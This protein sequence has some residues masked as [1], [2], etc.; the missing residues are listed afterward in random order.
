MTS[1]LSQFC[2]SMV[3]FYCNYLRPACL[4]CDLQRSMIVSFKAAVFAAYA[5]Y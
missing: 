5:K 1:I 4:I 3:T 2:N